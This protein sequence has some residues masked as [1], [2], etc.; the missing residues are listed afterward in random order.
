MR[1]FKQ[2][3]MVSAIGIEATIFLS[4]LI[5]RSN[6]EEKSL[7]LIDVGGGN[8]GFKLD[9]IDLIDETGISYIGI[10]NAISTITK[11]GI[12]T[13]VFLP[14]NNDSLWVMNLDR[15][16]DIEEG[17]ISK[18]PVENYHR[19]IID[20]DDIITLTGESKSLINNIFDR[21]SEG[22]DF[23][24]KEVNN[25]LQFI[26][27]RINPFY[28][29]YVSNQDIFN[30]ASFILLNNLLAIYILDD[31]IDTYYSTKLVIA[32]SNEIFK[33]L[34]LVIPSSHEDLRADCKDTILIKDCYET[35]M[36]ESRAEVIM[37]SQPHMSISPEMIIEKAFI[38]WIAMLS[39]KKEAR[40]EYLLPPLHNL[41]YIYQN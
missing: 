37:D 28:N 23:K 20:I 14:K 39:G 22:V 40:V 15:I 16:K 12:L 41:G 35:Q 1:L 30:T 3:Q 8:L 33:A 9:L 36:H 29:R 19:E 17:I 32:K 6:E 21:R 24:S 31:N 5:K 26:W 4:A 11:Q 10:L 13:K 2:E 38:Q 27:E 34:E 7:E 25:K 18:D